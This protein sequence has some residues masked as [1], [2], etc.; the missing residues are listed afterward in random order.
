MENC[1]RPTDLTETTIPSPAHG[2]SSAEVSQNHGCQ[3][4]SIMHKFLGVKA[5]SINSVTPLCTDCGG[6]MAFSS[7]VQEKYNT[8]VDQRLTEKS[9]IPQNEIR[10][11]HMLYSSSIMQGSMAIWLYSLIILVFHET[12]VVHN[13]LSYD[14]ANWLYCF[15]DGKRDT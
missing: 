11:K 6:S 2:C 7:W 8:T 14:Q 5:A 13:F 15:I 10:I 1:D 9:V 4:G 12:N 3:V